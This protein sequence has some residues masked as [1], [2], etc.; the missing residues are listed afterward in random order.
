MAGNLFYGFLCVR[1][2]PT[3]EYAK[4]VV[5]FG[6]LGSLCVLVDV[7]FSGALLPLI[8][9]GTDDH[10]KIADYV[11]SLRRLT[12]RLYLAVAPAMAILY[13]LFVRRQ[14]WNSSTVAAMVG[15]LLLALWCARSSGISG[16]VLIVCR[17]RAVWYRVQMASSLGTL[18]LLGIVWAVRGIDAFTAILINVAGIIFV[19]ICYFYRARRLLGVKG[20]RSREKSKEIIHLAAPNVPNTIFYALQGQISLL[21]ITFFGHAT[22]VASVGALSRLAQVFALFS[23]MTPFLIEPYFAKLPGERLK[24]NYAGLLAVEILLCGTVVLLARAFPGAFLWILGHRYSDLRYE[25]FLQMVAGSMGYLSGVLYILHNARRFVYWWSSMAF[26]VLP[27]A[28][29]IFFIVKVD[30]SSVRAV[31]T[32]SVTM[33]AATLLVNIL[34]GLYGF[35]YGPRSAPEFCVAP[36]EVG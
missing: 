5:V 23:Q 18:A 36:Q 19:G 20:H 6:F 12:G 17:D 9:E 1:L 31:L 24:R 7:G 4:F 25:V 13:P 8:G 10:Q 29:Q 3:S 30:L 15:I 32:L 22:A 26:I 34:T 27:T 35:V 2:L 14:H 28:V 33:A 16:S 11:T 21:L